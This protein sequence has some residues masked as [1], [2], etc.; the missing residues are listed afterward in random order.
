MSTT[1]VTN[2]EKVT[3]LNSADHP[4]VKQL[5]RGLANAVVLFMNYK[6]YHWRVAGPLFRDLHLMFDEFASEVE[7]AMDEMAERLRMI[8]QDPV[9]FDHISRE[10]T[11]AFTHQQHN[12]RQMLN[13]ADQATIQLIAETR[14]AVAASDEADDPGSADLFSDTVRI[15]EKQEWYFRELLK[16]TPDV[17]GTAQRTN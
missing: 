12:V 10:A 13:E 11:I 5:Q 15:Y 16:A 1:N 6:Q 9:H 14:D 8:G 4:V 3:S 17:L 2:L 7:K